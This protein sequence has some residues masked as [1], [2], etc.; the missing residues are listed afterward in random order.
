MQYRI[1]PI[2]TAFYCILPILTTFY[3]FLR[4]LTDSYRFLPIRG[5]FFVL[6]AK[7]EQRRIGKGAGSRG[8]QEGNCGYQRGN[9]LLLPL[10][11]SPVFQFCMP[12]SL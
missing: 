1:L 9:R 10:D 12:L 2:L 8:R 5:Y 4:L 7:K 11:S 3:R 6:W